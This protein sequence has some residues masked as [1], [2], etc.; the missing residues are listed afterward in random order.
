MAS[1][2]R[3]VESLRDAVVL[4]LASDCVGAC[5]DRVAAALTARGCTSVE[6]LPTLRMVNAVCPEADGAAADGGPVS[7]PGVLTVAADELLEADA[8]DT[9]DRE[10]DSTFA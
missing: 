8:L 7:I 4:T 3:M 2:E 6:M 10:G 1:T 9:E 5:Q